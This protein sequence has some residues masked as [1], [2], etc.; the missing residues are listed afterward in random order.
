MTT[1]DKPTDEQGGAYHEL[2]LDLARRSIAHNLATG[3]LLPYTPDGS[4]L[5]EPAA[6]FVTLRVRREAQSAAEEWLGEDL[7][8]CIGQIEA[9]KPLYAAV[10]DAAIKAATTDPRFYPV[11]PDELPNLWI[12]ISILSPLH[13]VERPE[14]IVVGRDGLLLVGPHQRGLLLPEVPVMYG[15]DRAEFLRA[16]H[17]KAGLPNGFWPEGWGEDRAWLYAFTTESFEEAH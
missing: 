4:R 15:W 17:S 13:L 14:D 10:Q 1:A 11:T 7:R 16:I 9:D 2:L 8:G 6:V 3:E 12:E 5:L